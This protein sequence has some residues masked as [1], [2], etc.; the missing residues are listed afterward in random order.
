MKKCVQCSRLQKHSVSL[1]PTPSLRQNLASLCICQGNSSS[2]ESI[3]GECRSY[4]R[5]GGGR[6]TGSFFC[7]K[8]PPVSSAVSFL[9]QFIPSRPH[10]GF[11]RPLPFS[12]AHP[13]SFLISSLLD[14]ISFISN[15]PP[16]YSPSHTQQLSHP[17][18]LF[19]LCP[20]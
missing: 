8:D 15:P 10:W 1:C 12:R 4:S 11:P 2:T 9:S 6:A 14:F 17:S 16:P 19:H 20:P 5:F 18:S 13:G 3:R 7:G